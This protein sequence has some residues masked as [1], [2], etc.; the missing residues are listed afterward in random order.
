MAMIDYGAI[1]F[2]NGKK[3]SH[4]M[5]TDMKE[6]VGWQDDGRHKYKDF[7]TNELIPLKLKDNYFVY[8][9]DRECTIAIYKCTVVFV[10]SFI[11]KHKKSTFFKE[12]E[13]FNCT[14]FLWHKYKKYFGSSCVI[15]KKKNGYYVLKWKYKN[16]RYK[17]Y[18]GYGVDDE[19][20]DKTKFIHFINYYKCPQFIKNYER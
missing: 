19:L 8:I 2:K 13:Y 7:S 11:D 17:V 4:G 9:G 3:I 16:D 10:E 1:A 14:N 20:Y 15:V 6:M 5:F 12:V 18:F